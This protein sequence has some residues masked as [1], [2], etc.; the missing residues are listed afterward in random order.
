M[1]RGRYEPG[2]D[3]PRIPNAVVRELH[4]QQWFGGKH[5][6]QI[7]YLWPYFDAEADEDFVE[8]D[9]PVSKCNAETTNWNRVARYIPILQQQG[10]MGAGLGA[11]QRQEARQGPRLH[12]RRQPPH[13]CGCGARA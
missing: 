9:V 7:N 13:A 12:H 2:V 3:I 4:H 6:G 11:L 1:T 5:A 8:V 10:S